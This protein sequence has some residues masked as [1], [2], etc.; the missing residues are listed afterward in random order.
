MNST[1]CDRPA[2]AGRYKT[3]M[4]RTSR[5]SRTA[6][7]VIAATAAVLTTP[8][9]ARADDASDYDGTQCPPGKFFDA[10]TQQCAVSTV[11]ND[12]QSLVDDLVSLSDPGVRCGPTDFYSVTNASCWPDTVTND[13]N[14]PVILEGEDPT[15]LAIPTLPAS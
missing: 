9:Q 5:P 15:P 2:A 6:L 3:P 12:P 10:T 4:T 13:P 7:S 14:A 8:A 1:H 11:T